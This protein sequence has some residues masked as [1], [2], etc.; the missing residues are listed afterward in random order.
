MTASTDS[1]EAEVVGVDSLEAAELAVDHPGLPE[2]ERRLNLQARG[3]V[4]SSSEGHRGINISRVDKNADRVGEEVG[5]DGEHGFDVVV[6]VLVDDGRADLP[7]QVVAN[8]DRRLDIGTVKPQLSLA[9]VDARDLAHGGEK[10]VLSIG[11]L[12]QRALI[13]TF[14][15]AKVSK[16]VKNEG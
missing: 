12:H 15:K 16:G 2:G 1:D 3:P 8:V 5:I 11:V 6:V 10:A 4:L 13:C 7:S 9:R 14:D